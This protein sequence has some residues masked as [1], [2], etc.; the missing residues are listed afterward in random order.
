MVITRPRRVKID[1]LNEMLVKIIPW[2]KPT[3]NSG[4]DDGLI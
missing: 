3:R 4:N 1:A 2:V